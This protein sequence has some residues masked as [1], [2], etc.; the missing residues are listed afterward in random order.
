MQ[1]DNWT[2]QIACLSSSLI[3][4]LDTISE[5]YVIW[6]K[7]HPDDLDKIHWQA[8]ERLTGEVLA[9]HGFAV[10]FT[11]QV[12]NKSSDILA[13]ESNTL[14]VDTKYLVECKRYSKT[15]KVDLTIVNAVLGAKSRANVDHALLITTSAFTR[16][17]IKEKAKL[18]DLR[19]H[20][21]DGEQVKEW[22]KEYEFKENGLWLPDNWDIDQSA[23]AP[24]T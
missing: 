8:F 21:R 19:L 23:R 2:S 10:Q 12:K 15:N 14:G 22:L 20:L 18:V 4:S 24:R 3:S 9:S 16:S 17:V 13:I 7:S 1:F 6:L 11:G 5:E